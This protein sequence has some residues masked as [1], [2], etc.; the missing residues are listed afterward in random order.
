MV[1]PKKR[2][3]QNF[4]IDEEVIGDIVAAIAPNKADF[5]LEIG[6]GQGA[7]TKPILELS[8]KLWAVEF[9]K[10]L[11]E[12]LKKSCMPIGELHVFV[13]DALNFDFSKWLPT[14]VK[15]RVFGNLPYNIS[16]PLIFHCLTFMD[17]IADMIFMLQQEVVNRLAASPGNKDYGRL[18]VMVQYYCAVKKLFTVAPL[19]FYPKPKVYSAV[20]RLVPYDSLPC[21]AHDYQVFA[22]LVKDA[23]AMRRKILSNAL[24]NKVTSAQFSQ[25]KINPLLRAEVLSVADFVR[26]AN[27]LSG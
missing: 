16:T 2:L 3:G 8:D 18:S 25:A 19:S 26:L 27:V 21:V 1:K 5:L 20:V 22:Q 15:G 10:E 14:G 11:V 12:A 6:P 24:K 13:Q 23:F 9:D 17:Y 4:L 7:L